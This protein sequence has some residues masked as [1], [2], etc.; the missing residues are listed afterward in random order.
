MMTCC[1]ILHSLKKIHHA[2]LDLIH[3]RLRESNIC[4]ETRESHCRHVERSATTISSSHHTNEESVQHRIL[5]KELLLVGPQPT[6]RTEGKHNDVNSKTVTVRH[7]HLIMS[8]L[9]TF[10]SVQENFGQRL[11]TSVKTGK[12]VSVQNLTVSKYATIPNTSS[13]KDSSW[14]IERCQLWC[15]NMFV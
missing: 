1:K 7:A 5:L 9:G 2:L 15:A 4:E 12:F 14:M 6:S 11:H 8:H 10:V 13:F 3:F